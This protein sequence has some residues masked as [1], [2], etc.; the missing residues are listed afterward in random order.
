[1]SDTVTLPALLPS[2]RNWLSQQVCDEV[3]SIES[4]HGGMISQVLRVTLPDS[5]TLVIKQ[6]PN[7]PAELFACEAAGL[8][9]LKLPNGPIVPEV[10]SVGDDYLIMQD[11]GSGNTPAEDYWEAYGR[12]VATVHSQHK[13]CYGFATNNYLGSFPME[14]RWM[15]DGYAFYGQT[16]ILTFLTHPQCDSLLTSDDRAR[17]ERLVG[18]LPELVP[19]QPASLLHGDLWHTNMLVGPHGEPAFLD[20]ATY[21]GW[22]EADLSMTRQYGNVPEQFFAAYNEIN[23]LADGWWE[24]LELYYIKE[25]L[26]TIVHVGD[27]YGTL[28]Q[29]RA[30]LARYV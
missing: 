4:M 7:A 25:Y 16:R 27:M 26:A 19:P 24:R 8:S 15:D 12:A 3:R 14:N 17:V 5:S 10:Y 2:V 18:R 21:Y 30:L 20:P 6:L 28:A 1:M 9:A 11:L 13:A 22:A 23:P 29:L